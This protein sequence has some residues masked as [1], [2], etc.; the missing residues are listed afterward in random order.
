MSVNAQL[1]LGCPQNIHPMANVLSKGI[2]K[3]ENTC[4]VSAQLQHT[5]SSEQSQYLNQTP[6]VFQ[7]LRGVTPTQAFHQE[8]NVEGQDGKKVYDIRHLS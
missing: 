3:M 4:R 5:Q 6:N 8:S 7:L 2:D 1:S